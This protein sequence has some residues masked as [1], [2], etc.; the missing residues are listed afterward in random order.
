MSFSIALSGINSVNS[1]L[2]V[3]SNN[4]ANSGSYGFKTSRAN[5]SAT[6]AGSQASGTQV[7]SMTQSMET[8]GGILTTGRSLDVSISGT[9]FFVTKDASG[10]E[11]YTRVGIFSLDTDGYLVDS[12]GNKVQGYQQAL[13]ANGNP[14]TG[15]ALGAIGNLQVSNGQIPA[16]AS[17][18]L[19]YAGNLSADWETKTAAF[20]KDDASTY[21]SSVV[22]V[23]YDSLGAQHT[24]SQYFVKTDTN[25][26]TVY[27]SFDGDQLGTT[28]TMSFDENGQLT[29]ADSVTV[30][31]GTPTGAAAMSIAIDYSGITQYAGSATTT[32]NSADGYASGAY[33]R[34]A[35]NEDGGIYAQYSNGETQKVGTIALATFVN[36]GGLVQ[37][38]DTAWT[39]SNASGTPLYATPGTSMAGTLVSGSLEE[40]NVNMTEQ[41]VDLMSA[42]RNYQA[43]TKVISAES[44][45]MQT[46]MQAI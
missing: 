41:L 44:E 4:I 31:L 8:D 40:S 11:L 32:T 35:V 28:A 25:E 21:N 20:D 13:D 2:D 18:S 46:L 42:Q 10:T 15:A 19:D 12:F 7:S 17:T 3:I 34:V 39:A 43:N 30:A 29:S 5:F 24:V 9:G 14:V 22:S 37:V 6:Y 26:V 1:Q 16:K 27:Y 33:T 38:S 23:V 45:M 36:Q